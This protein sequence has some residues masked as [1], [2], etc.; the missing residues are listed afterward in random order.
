MKTSATHPLRIDVVQ[1]LPNVGRIG[2]TFCPGKTQS[3]AAA[4]SWHRDLACDLDAICAWNA[5][6]V[7]TLIEDHEFDSLGVRN[8]GAEVRRR[9]MEWYHLPIPDGGTPSRNFESNWSQAGEELRR[10]LCN[11]FDVVVHCK[12][13][14]GRAGMIAAR[15]LVELGITSKTAIQAVRRARPGTIENFEQE[16]HVRSLGASSYP[17]AEGSLDAIRDRAMG[18]LVGLA[19][20][21]AVGT[22]LEF[23]QRDANPLLIDMVGGGPFRL[24]PGEWTDDTAMAL[25][26][27]GSLLENADLDPSDLMHRFVRWRDEGDYACTGSCF[28]IGMT[29]DAA[30]RGWKG[31]GNPYAGSIDPMTAGNG[32]LMRLAPVAVRFWNDKIKMADVACRQSQTTHAAPEAVS[33]CIHFA[34]LLA[35][36]IGGERSER[37]VHDHAL[38][39]DDLI[40]KIVAGSWRGKPRSE[41]RAS[42]YVAHSL[43]A[44]LW[45]VGRTGSFERAVLTAAN[46][47]EDADTTAA[48]TGQLA[49]AIY[50]LQGIPAA[51]LERLAWKDKIVATS[52]HLFDRSLDA[53]RKI[54]PNSDR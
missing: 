24:A 2:I 31:T 52:S 44:A 8:L 36:A 54:A 35:R 7:V 25:A 49:G 1:T 16:E 46:L 42:G 28:D 12:G 20:G 13:G 4:G 6:A 48:I 51:W 11:G 53:R 29:V 30:L 5:A 50:G 45:S 10:I 17:I 26:L 33:A 3:D 38:N 39:N 23:S 18:A 22:T 32:S 19:I 15:L 9:H 21:D 14:L 41:V 34:A 47:G 27:A 40:A 43:E 37:S